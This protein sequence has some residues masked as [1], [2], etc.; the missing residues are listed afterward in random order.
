MIALSPFAGIGSEGYV[1]LQCGR[2]FV[3]I[4]LK[5]SY[6]RTALQNLRSA[7]QCAQGELFARA[8]A[9]KAWALTVNLRVISPSPRPNSGG[10]NGKLIR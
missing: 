2:K 10:R 5:E 1:A 3:G 7:K 6:W 9:L 8:E 4:E